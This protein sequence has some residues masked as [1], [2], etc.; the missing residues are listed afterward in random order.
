[1][2]LNCNGGFGNYF[3]W[4]EYST[5]ALKKTL[6]RHQRWSTEKKI[7]DNRRTIFRY[8]PANRR[9]TPEATV[10]LPDREEK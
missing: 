9:I 5:G 7:K 1:M 8:L 4:V 6:E 3:W 10:H 2:N